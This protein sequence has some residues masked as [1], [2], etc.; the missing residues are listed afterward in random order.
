MASNFG[1]SVKGTVTGVPVEVNGPSG[2]RKS[3]PGTAQSKSRRQKQD[4]KAK[5]T[6]DD[7]K[8]MTVIGAKVGVK[9]AFG[10]NVLPFDSIQP[11][12]ITPLGADKE[13]L[14]RVVF[15]V[16]K[17]LSVFDVESCD[18]SLLQDTP[19][20]VKN[21]LHFTISSNHKYLSVCESVRE[22]KGDEGHAQ[23]AIYN[24]G[25]LVRTKVLTFETPA[26]FVMS[27]FCLDGK[28]LASLT[29][30][31]DRQI[32]VWLWEKEKIHKQVAVPFPITR[33]RAGPSNSLMLSSSGPN[34]LKS[35]FLGADG[36]FKTGPFLPPNK[37][38]E[39]F[40]DHVWLPSAGGVVHRM[41]AL[42]DDNSN[43]GGSTGSV[44]LSS[45][46]GSVGGGSG[47]Q[48]AAIVSSF[49]KQLV[50][51]FEGGDSTGS[52]GSGQAPVTMELRQSMV[53]RI[54]ALPHAVGECVI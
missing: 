38:N 5:S 9:H 4:T 26:E 41:V 20:V 10:S 47:G 39:Q 17:R 31:L 36:S 32:I 23:I 6:M 54:D 25:T 33:L 16:G 1:G 40:V 43:M 3:T 2:T 7:Q 46:H 48:P 12:T 28:H 30:D 22:E 49:R 29:D 45:E 37:E 51:I 21:I 18:H 53:V 13:V 8:Q 27:T 52:S 50:I 44:A 35:W 19:K 15:R 24:L 14:E 42:C 34:S 11:Y